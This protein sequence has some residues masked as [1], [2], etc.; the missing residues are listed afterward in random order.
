MSVKPLTYLLTL[1]LSKY[2]NDQPFLIY[3]SLSNIQIRYLLRPYAANF[4][5]LPSAVTSSNSCPILNL[6]S[7]V[8]TRLSCFMVNS[9]ASSVMVTTGL[10]LLPSFLVTRPTPRAFINSSKFSLC[11]SLYLPVQ[12][13]MM[14]GRERTG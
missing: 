13:A 7:E 5:C 2:T 12:A 4:P 14:S 1:P 6:I 3:P 10:D 8:L 9:P 11:V